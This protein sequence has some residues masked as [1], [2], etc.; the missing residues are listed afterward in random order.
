MNR[1][2]FLIA[3]W[4]LASC[5]GGAKPPAI[6]EELPGGWKRASLSTPPPESAPELARSLGVKLVTEAVF[7]GPGKITVTYY[8]MGASAS[9]FELVQK[10]KPEPGEVFLSEGP[11]F[12]VA[13]G[14]MLDGKPVK[15]IAKAIETELRR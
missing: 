15:E 3:A 11:H 13:R 4:L 9:A 14:P 2:R 6:P 12:V 8:T 1:F 7:S 5:G 10:W